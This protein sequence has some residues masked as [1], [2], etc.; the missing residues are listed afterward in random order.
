MLE[1][2]GYRSNEGSNHLFAI[3]D[4]SGTGPGAPH[5]AET[6]RFNFAVTPNVKECRSMLGGLA[7]KSDPF[8]AAIQMEA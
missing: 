6:G 4:G 1:K 8:N 5:F 2:S 3:K 7:E